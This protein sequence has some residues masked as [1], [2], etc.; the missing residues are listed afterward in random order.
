MSVGTLALRTSSVPLKACWVMHQIAA[1]G[2]T[3]A[4]LAT[5]ERMSSSS[6]ELDRSFVSGL[7]W[8]GAIR[9]LGQLASWAIT[10]LVARL[11]T[12]AD[13]GLVGMATGYLGFTHLLDRK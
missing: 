12:P 9:W 10:I 8:T 7:A 13:Y 1:C 5:P 6:R 4:A 2:K 11:L 3:G